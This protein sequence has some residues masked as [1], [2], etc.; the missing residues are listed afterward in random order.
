M[1]K[2]TLIKPEPTLQGLSL[3]I[4]AS[5]EDFGASVPLYM[6]PVYILSEKEYARLTGE[7]LAVVQNPVSVTLANVLMGLEAMR[8]DIE[9]AQASLNSAQGRVPNWP[10]TGI[11]VAP[12]TDAPL[13]AD[14]MG[15]S[16]REAMTEAEQIEE[17]WKRR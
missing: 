15:D 14:G 7:G 5:L 4:K 12:L 17:T 3:N 9:D 2:G 10:G 1:I 6:Q 13:D 8:A 16:M 11:P